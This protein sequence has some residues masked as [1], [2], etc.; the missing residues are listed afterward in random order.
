[1]APSFSTRSRGM[2]SMLMSLLGD[3]VRQQREM[4]RAFDSDGK[5]P[6]LLGRNGGDAGG[7][8]LALLRDVALEELH[9]LVVDRR[10]VGAGERA[11]LATTAERA[12][13]G[14]VGDVD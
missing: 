10:G 5:Q 11:N 7:N 14:Q 13:R 4:P 2:T 3:D 8:D 9:V 1:M 6:L 12:A